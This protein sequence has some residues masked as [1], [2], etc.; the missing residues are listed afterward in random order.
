MSYAIYLCY[1]D[2][3]G[4]KYASDYS[5]YV[6]KAFTYINKLDDSLDIGT[7]TIRNLTSSEPFDLFNWIEIYDETPPD[8]YLDL[9]TEP[10]ITAR[11]FGDSVS[12]MSKNPVLYQHELTLV[13]H[14][15]ILERFIVSGKTFRQP[16]DKSATPRY[17]L[18]DV[19][20]DLVD[21]IPLEMLSIH[22][23]YR[24]FTLPTSGDNYDL[25]TTT[26]SP[27][28]TFKDVTLR[29][30]LN[31]VLSTVDAVARLE[32]TSDGDLVLTAD[33]QNE[34][35]DIIASE[36][37]FID[38]VAQQ[39]G[40]FYATDLESEALNAVGDTYD[41]ESIE[42]YPSPSSFVTPRTDDIEF[43]FLRSYIPTPKRI[44]NVNKVV[45]KL[46]GSFL[47]GVGGFL[48]YDSDNR[49]DV[50]SSTSEF[51]STGS[52]EI[53]YVDKSD[54]YQ[55]YLWDG[56]SYNAD[57]T[58]YTTTFPKVRFYAS[59]SDFEDPDDRDWFIARDSGIG[60]WYTGS[61]YEEVPYLD[62]DGL[63]L[64]EITDRVI[65]KKVYDTLD[66][67]S[68]SNSDTDRTDPTKFYQS[69][70]VYYQYR[71]KNVPIGG[72]V[73]IFSIDTSVQ[74]AIRAS[75]NAQFS[76]TEY[77]GPYVGFNI[78]VEDDM[79]FQVHY[80]PIPASTRLNIER[81]D[82][83]DVSYNTT[84]LSNQQSRIIEIGNFADN[85]HGRI[86]RIGNA[87][88]R[89]EH[90]VASFDDLYD[91]GDYTSDFYIVTE[92]ELIFYKDFILARYSLTRN[93]NQLSKFI[94]VNTEIRQWDIGEQ[95]TLDR[96]LM[97]K[98]YIEI[99]AVSSGSGSDTSLM[100]TDDGIQTY[101]DTLKPSSALN[102][103]RTGI[104]KSSEV[105]DY[106][107][108]PF[109]SVGGGNSLSFTFALESNRYVG[110]FRDE[111]T[112][113]AKVVNDYA[114]YTDES[115]DMERAI[116]Y[117]VDDIRQDLDKENTKSIANNFPIVDLDARNKT[118]MI[119][120]SMV[121]KK[122]SAEI[123]NGTFQLQ[124]VPLEY[125][126]III[127]RS[128]SSRNRMVSENPPSTIKLY[129]STTAS[130]ARTNN[131]KFNATGFTQ[132]T[133]PTLTFD[134]VNKTVTVSHASLTSSSTAWV[135]TDENDNVLIGVNQSGTLTN[136]LT[137]DF[138]N[139]RT[140]KR[141]KY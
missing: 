99:D 121:I 98:E 115:G 8:D 17:Y 11:I 104:M 2:E 39:D 139:K 25:W 57:G 24:L 9:T 46:K 43:N 51:P 49:F 136:V 44:Y 114:A 100:F 72:T 40:E 92:R 137:F 107:I 58:S 47:Y 88:L 77:G 97:Y 26:K 33:Y 6:P 50:Y 111:T 89:L 84:L 91:V 15:K 81:D 56:S 45:H 69:N 73:G 37:E 29:E 35:K 112:Y 116:F 106:L 7:I 31:Q 62:S 55:V 22:S 18:Y 78:D 120:G 82:L 14:T 19:L 131:R 16:I 93:F 90:R 54:G 113:T 127:G 38:K 123:I 21:T 138:V 125:G 23:D 42:V 96:N 132:L 85:L 52:T 117:F 80:V 63:F 61:D 32:L 83:T 10:I 36:S 124:Q 119:T 71:E 110:N 27:E 13:E 87:D 53:Y 128:M 141:Y 28:F 134:Y 135:L 48:A 126:R 105:S 133:S 4:V 79:L 76:G 5:A 140:G 64:I 12:L 65:E 20:Q 101:M 130:I 118:L 95:N 60:Y 30:A 59:F 74:Y 67:D 41:G 66:S 70:T 75:A 102:P 3:S 108:V 109:S 94:G 86:N 103:V 1:N 129:H 34:I 122:D 68:P